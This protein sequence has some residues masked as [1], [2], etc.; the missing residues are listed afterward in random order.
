MPNTVLLAVLMISFIFNELCINRLVIFF[1]TFESSVQLVQECD[2]L[3]FMGN[4]IQWFREIFFRYF[5]S[6]LSS[7]WDFQ[8]MVH[9]LVVHS[10]SVETW[11]IRIQFVFY[12]LA[13]RYYLSV[14]DMPKITHTFWKNSN[15]DAIWEPLNIWM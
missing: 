3:K 13:L 1:W 5:I 6:V 12:C 10:F 2:K 11:F 8:Q 4:S 9:G 7:Q 15:V 14:F